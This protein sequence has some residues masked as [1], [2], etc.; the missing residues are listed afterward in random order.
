M[1]ISKKVYV[2]EDIAHHKWIIWKLRKSK[3]TEDIYCIV[4]VENGFLE[5]IKSNKIK[6]K[7]KKSVLIG[8]AATRQGAMELLVRIFDDVYVPNPNI[9]HMKDYFVEDNSE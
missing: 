7:Y 1:K 5:I 6:D 2:D 8:M 4:Y 9:Q 3:K